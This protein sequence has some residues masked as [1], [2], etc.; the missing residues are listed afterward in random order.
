MLLGW[1]WFGFCTRASN[2]EGAPG[3]EEAVV[4]QLEEEGEQV[5]SKDDAKLQVL[6]V[7]VDVWQGEQLGSHHD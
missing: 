6:V 7:L 3:V 2:V 4:D 1:F 5:E